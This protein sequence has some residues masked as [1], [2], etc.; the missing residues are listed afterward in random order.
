VSIRA[1]VRLC[2]VSA[3][4]ACPALKLVSFQQGI[5]GSRFEERSIP[6]R[7]GRMVAPGVDSRSAAGK[8][9]DGIT[10]RLAD[11]VAVDE[12]ARAV[13]EP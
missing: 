8:H 5:D 7:L 9:G 3:V 11:V 6:A 2:G 1:S 4:S 10:A 12:P 13:L